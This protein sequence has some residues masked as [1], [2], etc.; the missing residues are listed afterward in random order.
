MSL[1]AR[2]NRLVHCNDIGLSYIGLHLL[3]QDW[4]RLG[5]KDYTIQCNAWSLN[6]LFC[7]CAVICDKHVS[8]RMPID[9]IVNSACKCY[10][11]LC[12]FNASEVYNAKNISK[13][14]LYS[15][16]YFTGNEVF[17]KCLVWEGRVVL[18]QRTV[19][20]SPESCKPVLVVRTIR[21]SQ[22]AGNK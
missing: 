13:D 17:G 15:V 5:P 20:C 18:A 8:L 12:A 6:Q 19:R 3:V 1:Q 16:H 21:R 14:K 7:Y 22:R 9:L 2:R 4:Y 11:N 10:C